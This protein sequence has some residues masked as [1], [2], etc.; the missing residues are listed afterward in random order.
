[1]TLQKIAV[2]GAGITGL[3]AACILHLAGLDVHVFEKSRGLGGRLATRRSDFGI[4]NHGAQFATAR[5]PDFIKYLKMAQQKGA[6]EQWVPTPH[7]PQQNNNARSIPGGSLGRQNHQDSNAGWFRG[8]PA[9]N[10]LV[11]PLNCGFTINKN[12]R[13]SAV[14]PLGNEQFEL[15]SQEG[16]RSGHRIKPQSH[17]IFDGVIVAIPA[18]QC[19]EILMPLSPRFDGIGDVTMAPC[20]AVMIAFQNKAAT[21][22]DVLPDAH[23]DI[24]WI[25]RNPNNAPFA[26]PDNMFDRWTIHASPQWSQDHLEDDAETVGHLIETRLRSLFKDMN[27]TTPP[28][29]MRQAHRWRYARTIKPL[30]QS[31]LSSLDGRIVAAGDWC[32]GARIEAAFQSGE[33]AARAIMA[34]CK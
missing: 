12:T 6:A 22:F 5:H 13:I 20:W 4:F 29:V 30:G 28:I 1:M 7:V 33:S 3:N 16:P 10:N 32:M 9:M 24:A 26:A 27:I 23:P 15:L 17:G 21:G 8:T 11:A 18:P 19:A 14:R 25:G 2:I 34:V 31:H